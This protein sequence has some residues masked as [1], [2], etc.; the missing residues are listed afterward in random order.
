MRIASFTCGGALFAAGVVTA[1]FLGQPPLKTADCRPTQPLTVMQTDHCVDADSVAG[2]LSIKDKA[3]MNRLLREA[4]TLLENEQCA[5]MDL[6]MKQLELDRCSLELPTKHDPPEDETDLYA[7]ARQSVV[8]VG[9]IYKCGRCD[10]W[11]AS[12][13]TGFVIS[14]E[15]AIVTNYHVVD[16]E[17]KESLVIMTADGYV[18]PVKRILAASKRDDLAILKVDVEGL[19]PLTLFSE[20]PEPRVGTPISVI[21]HPAGHF[22]S[23]TTGVISRYMDVPD[24]SGTFSAFAITAD[25]AR[26]SSG[27]PVMNQQGHVVGIVRSTESIYYSVTKGQQNNLQ[28]VYKICIPVASLHKLLEQAI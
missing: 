11:H 18:T 1:T 15:G 7:R 26:G 25:Y 17:N 28:M 6:L 2:P 4:S 13:A 10:K 23:F 14:A 8:T 5:D 22:Y 24:S 12:T 16:A 19:V 20:S 3:I 21:S 27:A 9:G